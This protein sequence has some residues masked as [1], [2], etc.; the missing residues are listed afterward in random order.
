MATANPIQLF[1]DPR[2]FFERR[3]NYPEIRTAGVIVLVLSIA[4]MIEVIALWLNIPILIRKEYLAGLLIFF[5]INLTTPALLWFVYSIWIRIAAGLVGGRTQELRI[6]T[7][8]RFTGWGFIP[9]ILAPLA[10]AIGR[11]QYYQ[12]VTFQSYEIGP[13]IVLSMLDQLQATEQMMMQ[14]YRDTTFLAF[15]VLGVVFLLISGYLW[16]TVV[17]MVSNVGRAKAAVIAY[18]PVVAFA[19]MKLEPAL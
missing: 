11:Y 5:G 8:M 3:L 9:A 6:Y 7:I 17:E 16:I 4:N 19:L 1:R 13:L 10:W 12:D 15:L 18:L 2:A 14:A